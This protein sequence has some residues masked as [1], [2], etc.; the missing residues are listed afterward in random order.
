MSEKQYVCPQCSIITST[1][2]LLVDHMLSHTIAAPVQCDKCSYISATYAGLTSHALVHTTTP[3]APLERLRITEI[4]QCPFAH[5][6][7][8]GVA[9]VQCSYTHHSVSTLVNHIRTHTQIKPFTCPQCP[10]T[11][12]A[13]AIL[14]RHLKH[15]TQ[16][17]PLQCPHCSLTAS[18]KRVMTRHLSVHE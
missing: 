12:T 2:G 16:R 4:H 7:A 10:Y 11:C 15:H 1:V 8:H 13:S 18:Q 17:Q 14:M 9:S 6:L 3:P 5:D